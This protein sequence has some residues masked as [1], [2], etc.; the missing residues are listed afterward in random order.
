MMTPEQRYLFDLNGYLHLEQALSEEELTAAQSAAER[1]INARPKDLPPEFGTRDRRL[2]DHGFAF[3]K[4]LERLIFHPSYW[5]IVKEFTDNKPRFLRGTMLVNQP[6]GPVD[7]G[8]L[9]CARESY[10]WQSTRYECRNGRIYCDDFVIFPYLYDVHPGDGGLV[11]LP[12]SHKANFDRP[13]TLFHG[14]HLD[15]GLPPGVVNL[16]AK[17][18]DVIIISELLTHG[19]LRWHPTDRK[20]VVLVL[21]YAPQY[22]GG[23][24]WV[25]DSLKK[26][27]S[28]ETIE[29]MS[30]GTHTEIKDVVQHDIV[31]FS[32]YDQ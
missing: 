18:G 7:A 3:D 22:R 17:A 30:S 14:G 19:G 6:G 10:G 4:A 16:S 28:S 21:R 15:D 31:T 24:G 5:P 2:Y 32:G 26:R 12:G 11:V 27:L 13:D 20:R 23:E 29:L 9:H 25:P 1:Y 8:S